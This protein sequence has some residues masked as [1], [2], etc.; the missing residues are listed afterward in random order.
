MIHKD[1][2]L[3]RCITC[4]RNILM[5]HFNSEVEMEYIMY[6]VA[7]EKYIKDWTSICSIS[8]RKHSSTIKNK[9]ATSQF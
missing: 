2:I 3:E 8:P 5:E 1:V 9:Q 6:K 7:D 4:Y